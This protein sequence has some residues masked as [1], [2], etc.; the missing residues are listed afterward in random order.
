MSA[1]LTGINRSF[2][3]AKLSGFEFDDNV[4]TLYKIIQLSKFNVGV[5]ALSIMFQV[6]DVSANNMNADR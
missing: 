2:S 3:L 5:Q 6:T 4:N 1:L